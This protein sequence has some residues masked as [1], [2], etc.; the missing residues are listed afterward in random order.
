MTTTIEQQQALD[1]LAQNIEQW[2][3]DL[4]SW[5]QEDMKQND[6]NY[7]KRGLAEA[8]DGSWEQGYYQKKLEDVMFDSFLPSNRFFVESGRK[9]FKIM[10]QSP[11]NSDNT[12]HQ[13]SV[14]AFVD[15]KT[16][17]VY[18]PAS[19]RGPAKHVRYDLRL[20]RDRALLQNKCDWAGGYLYMR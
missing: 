8:E 7:V 15:K 14:H 2:T 20:I 11:V 13:I 9:Y 5:L 1:V 4:C 12:K 3:L 10:M 18:K 17:Q 16:G 6:I 19:W